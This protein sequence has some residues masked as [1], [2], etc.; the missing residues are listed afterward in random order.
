MKTAFVVGFFDPVRKALNTRFPKNDR[1]IWIEP[2]KTALVVFKE[3]FYDVIKTADDIL[4]C[5]GRSGSQRYLEEAV[6]GIIGVAQAQH[7]ATVQFKAFGNLYDSAP[8]V[9]LVE[10][11][12]L[13]TEPLIDIAQLRFKVA[14]GKILCVSIEGK[15]SIFSALLRAGFSA[16]VIREC[17]T[18]E[19]YKSGRNSNLMQDLKSRAQSHTCLL[20]AWGGLRT[21]TPEVKN[22]YKYGCHEASTASQVVELF[23]KLFAEEAT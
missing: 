6:I 4:V 17:F 12:G 18:E 11:F 1:L 22:A 15:T 21:S 20:Y 19:Q 5:L 23:K 13:K 10:S 8:V 9:E 2:G 7:A 16:D 3:R 14:E